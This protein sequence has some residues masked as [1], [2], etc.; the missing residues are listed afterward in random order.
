MA[1]WFKAPVL[2]TEPAGIASTPE[3][4]ENH[5]ASAGYDL[6]RL[7]RLVVRK[8]QKWTVGEAEWYQNSYQAGAPVPRISAQ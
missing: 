6:P 1:E 3:D 8:G 5:G 7:L 4:E 2:K